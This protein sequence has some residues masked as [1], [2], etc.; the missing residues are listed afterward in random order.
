MKTIGIVGGIGPDST[1]DYYKRFVAEGHADI[2]MVSLDVEHLLRLM[3]A[4]AY[5]K[6]VDYLAGATDRLTRAGAAVGLIAANTPHIVFDEVQARTKIPLVSIVEAA[7]TYA[8]GLGYR[9]VGLFGTRFTMEADFYPQVF[10]KGGI[11]VFVPDAAERDFL[12]R[13]YVNELL[14][15]VFSHTTADAVLAIARQVVAR[16]QLDAV[17][18]AGTELPLLLPEGARGDV[19][20]LDTTAMHVRAVLEASPEAN[21]I[22]RLRKI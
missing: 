20:F 13:I 5:P 4:A 9:R 15:G 16:D 11:D 12:H 14:R 8:T 6:I 18:L 2:V 22:H 19:Q 10:T 7:R 3:E 17:I 1:V 21:N